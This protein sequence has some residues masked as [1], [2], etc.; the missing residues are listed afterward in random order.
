M[1][2]EDGFVLHNGFDA[3]SS[4]GKALILKEAQQ[5]TGYGWFKPTS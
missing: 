5:R 4:C 1:S 3:F 2:L